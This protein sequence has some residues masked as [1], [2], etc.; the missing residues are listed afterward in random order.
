[1]LRPGRK[2]KSDTDLR[3]I[4][5]LGAVPAI[6]IAAPLVGFFMGQWADEKFATEPYLVIAG[7]VLG[8]AAAGR[9]IYRLVRK[10]SAIE[11]EKDNEQRPRT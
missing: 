10:S 5:L 7:V 8:F 1:M 4:A 3:Q 6:L 11:R 9:E 2:N